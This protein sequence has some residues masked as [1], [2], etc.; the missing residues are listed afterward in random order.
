MLEQRQRDRR[1]LRPSMFHLAI[2]GLWLALVTIPKPALLFSFRHSG[3]APH[4]GG[5]LPSCLAATL[6]YLVLHHPDMV[7]CLLGD[8]TLDALPRPETPL[9]AHPQALSVPADCLSSLVAPCSPPEGGVPSTSPA[10]CGT[11]LGW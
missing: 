4:V 8:S 10:S 3:V 7:L 5:S 11:A 2:P 1:S 6:L 9:L